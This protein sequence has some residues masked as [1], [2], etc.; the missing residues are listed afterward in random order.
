VDGTPRFRVLVVDDDEDHR[1]LSRRRLEMA[2]IAVSAAGNAEEALHSL[3]GVDLVLLDHRLPGMSGL[4]LLPLIKERG[5]SVVMVT[6]MGSEGLAVEAMRRGAVDYIVKDGSYHAILPD[7]VERAWHHHDLVRRT[8]ELER[9]GLLVTSASARPEVFTEVVEGARRLLRADG[10]VLFVLADNGLTQEAM[11]G[12]QI[13]E[14][15]QL[16]GEARRLIANPQFPPP[17][18]DRLLVPVPPSEERPVGVL[19]VL[20]R[21]PREFAVEEQR[22]AR[23]LASYAGIALGNLRRLDLERALVAELQ[24]MLDMRRELMASVSHELRTP[25]TCVSGFAETLRTHWEALSEDERQLFVEKICHHSAEL[26]DLVDRL[27]D[28]SE[29]ESGQVSAGI[30]SLDLRDEID[31]TVAALSPLMTDRPVEIRVPHWPVLADSVLLRRTLVNLL[32]NAVK[33]SDHGSPIVVRAAATHGSVRVEVIDRGVGL[34][35][36][37]AVRAFDPFWRAAHVATTHL[38]GT[39]LGLALVKE[40]VRVMGGEVHVV[41]KPGEGS[42][43]LFTLPVAE[44]VHL[45]ETASLLQPG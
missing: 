44:S 28:F 27:L 37:E 15:A 35:D 34:T 6:G 29:L 40:Y 39:G 1:Y 2:G 17:G 14:R 43:F 33:Y 25:L 38:R 24:Q 4:D 21:E 18:K 5:P 42:T 31:A 11:A 12:S 36:E 19:A 13:H 32:S 16:L 41:S 45:E 20:F 7:V 30:T 3:E 9:I 10:C 22:L 8:G 26:G 23:T